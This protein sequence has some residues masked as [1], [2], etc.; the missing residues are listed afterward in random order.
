VL[1]VLCLGLA[2]GSDEPPPGGPEHPRDAFRRAVE[3]EAKRKEA[4]LNRL[5]AIPP[6]P[7]GELVFAVE[8]DDDPDE[9]LAQG[10]GRVLARSNFEQAVFGDDREEEAQR[11]RLRKI[12]AE[13]IERAARYNRL[14][15][16]H[17]AKL[18]LAGEGDMKRF[19]DHVAAKRREFEVARKNLN[20]GVRFLRGLYPE[21][22]DY[23]RGPFGADSLYEKTLNKILGEEPARIPRMP[24]ILER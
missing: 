11:A 9:A 8:L 14:T 7:G 24:T 2:S 23:F 15:P 16:G 19:F 4:I 1:I 13:Q 10:T 17:R 22:A 12:L 5:R 6:A 18:R 3:A 20:A 21:Q